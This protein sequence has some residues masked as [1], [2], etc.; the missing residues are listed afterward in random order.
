M[1]QVIDILLCNP[2]DFIVYRI[3]RARILEQVVIP[4]SR[5]SSKPRDWTQVSHIAGE[6]CTSWATGEAQ[7]NIKT[8]NYLLSNFV[9]S[10]KY[11]QPSLLYGYRAF[12][13]ISQGS[14][15]EDFNHGILEHCTF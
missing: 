3:L 4:F 10:H 13:V 2:M 6:V 15:W 11:I 8:K 14:I 5:G 9:V 7:Y 1:Y 12:C